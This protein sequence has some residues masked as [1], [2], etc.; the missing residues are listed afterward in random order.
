MIIK[1][2]DK[3]NNLIEF[4]PKNNFKRYQVN[5]ETKK[6]MTTTIGDRFKGGLLNWKQSVVFE[7]MGQVF[8]SEKLPVDLISKYE[9]LIRARVKEIE[10][11]ATTIGSNFHEIAEQYALAKNPPEPQTEPLVTMFNK[12]KTFWDASGY[13]VVHTEMPVYSKEIDV[14]GTFDLII[15]KDKW[16]DKD[17]NPLYALVDMKTSK[18]FYVDQVLQIH[19]Y[20]KLIED[21]LDIK[22]SKLGVLNIPKEPNKD[23]EMRWYKYKPMFLNAVKACHYLTKVQVK[24]NDIEKERKKHKA[25]RRPNG[26]Q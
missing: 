13:K 2:T 10:S 1:Q 7:A 20:K 9:E 22:I 8:R 12:F 3:N 14:A 26:K 19:G 23:I 16:K 4:N 21:S 6:G 17:G 24:F 11:S 25:N 15:T 18:D 5:G